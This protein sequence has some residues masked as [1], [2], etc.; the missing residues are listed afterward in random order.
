MQQ[1]LDSLREGQ[2]NDFVRINLL[3]AEAVQVFKTFEAQIEAARDTFD[4]KCAEEESDGI[5]DELVKITEK[6]SIEYAMIMSI[7]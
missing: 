2:D 6:T 7:Y 5:Y 4:D 3:K 1:A